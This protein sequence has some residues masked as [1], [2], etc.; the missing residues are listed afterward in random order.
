MQNANRPLSPHLQVYRLPLAGKMSI[1]HRI[2]GVALAGG[3]VLFAWWLIA[4]AYGP[5]YFGVAQDFLSSWFGRLILFGLTLCFT[6]HF[7]NGLRHLKWDAG[8]GLT[9]EKLQSSGIM[10]L[11]LTVVLTLLIWIYVYAYEP[12]GMR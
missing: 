1:T 3:A 8:K 5:E 7:L 4:A 12:G 10:V 6:Y 11:G 2:T 9:K